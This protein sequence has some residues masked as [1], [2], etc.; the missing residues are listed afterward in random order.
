MLRLRRFSSAALLFLLLLHVSA[1]GFELAANA[2]QSRK[3]APQT[4]VSIFDI[5]PGDHVAKAIKVIGVAPSQTFPRPANKFYQW[6]HPDMS[7]E[8]WT[9]LEDRILSATFR[10]KNAPILTPDGVVLG[11]DSLE[12]A[13][14]KLGDRYLGA[15]SDVYRPEPDCAA[16]YIGAKGS[17]PG[18][19][20]NYESIICRRGDISEEEL[21]QAPINNMSR[22]ME[23]FIEPN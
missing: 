15:S 10:Y 3:R 12:K 5:Y 21:W 23:G 20:I 14:A 18:W 9:D 4:Q 19:T 6:F 16:F 13:A 17:N 2:S 11:R 7:V 22:Q 8:I 1:G